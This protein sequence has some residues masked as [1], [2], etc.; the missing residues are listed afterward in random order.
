[1]VLVLLKEQSPSL[2]EI[3]SRREA[4]AGTLFREQE[5]QCEQRQEADED[6]HH[7]DCQGTNTAR[8]V[9]ESANIDV[10]MKLSHL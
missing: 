9:E 7:N 1:M 10:P 2:R 5:H 3:I 8:F 6:H 4:D